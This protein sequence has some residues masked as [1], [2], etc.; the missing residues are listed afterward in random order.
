MKSF[1]C[2]F[3]FVFIL[4]SINVVAQQN[5]NQRAFKKRSLE[6]FNNEIRISE[7]TLQQTY[8]NQ[9]Y[10]QNVYTPE[11]FTSK[12]EHEL[13][14]KVNGLMNLEADRIL[15]VF[16]LTQIGENAVEVDD[17]INSRINGLKTDVQKLGIMDKDI[18]VDMIYLIP[19]FEY[20][21]EKKLFS[22]TYNEVPAG[23]EMQKNIHI[24]FSDINLVDDIVTLAAK[25]EIYELVK[26]DY[27]VE[28]TE[29][30]YD[31]LRLRSSKLIK[32]KLDI[33]DDLDLQLSDTFHIINESAYAIYP[34]SQYS[35]YE[36]FVSQSIEAVKKK[37]GVTTI[38]KPKT[39]AYDQVPYNK[40]D[41]IINPYIHQPAV[42]FIYSLEIKYA[43]IRKTPEKPQQ[44]K[45][46][47]IIT[48]NGDIKK[49]NDY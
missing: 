20:E 13:T 46:Y 48:P 39:I 47:F 5:S 23:F 25:N 45:N 29:A 12:L 44:E 19:M 37:S 17:L 11:S 1:A 14:I 22:K 36:G 26:M 24:S 35:D 43:I 40:F 4:S 34:E 18:Y 28:N 7:P 2:T 9:G 10:T 30:A 31:T 38:R 32:K 27:F 33:Y 6:N 3:L 21:V 15:L 8:D 16:N 42:Q 41:L 49:L